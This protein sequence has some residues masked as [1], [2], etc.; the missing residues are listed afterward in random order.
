MYNSKVAA[1]DEVLLLTPLSEASFLCNY[2]KASLDPW[3]N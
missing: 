3:F 1:T 2:V